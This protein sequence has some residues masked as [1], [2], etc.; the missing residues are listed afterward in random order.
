[1]MSKCAKY[2]GKVASW[3]INFQAPNLND[4]VFWY[5]WAREEEENVGVHSRRQSGKAGEGKSSEPKKK[6][7]KCCRTGTVGDAMEKLL[8]KLPN[9]LAH[10]FVKREQSNLFQTKR[11]SIPNGSA[12]IQV[13]FSEN[14]TLQHEKSSQQSG[15]KTS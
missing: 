12:V 1:M 14:Y 8:E 15:I 4:N 2:S 11:L 10:V 13:D 5:E 7:Q 6:M 3:L 9:F